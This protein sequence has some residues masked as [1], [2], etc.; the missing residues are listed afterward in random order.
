MV[1]IGRRFH[2]HL[3]RIARRFTVLTGRNGVGKS[4]ILDAI[5]FALTGTISKFAVTGAKGGGLEE[6]IWWVGEG[7][8]D[9]HFVTVRFL[10]DD[11][12]LLEVTRSRDKG[13]Q[14]RVE[15]LANS[16][17]TTATPVMDGWAETLIRT[18]L[19][20]DET[21]AALSLDLPEQARFAAVRSANWRVG[22]T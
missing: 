4:T 17:C 15:D 19:I 7:S 22:W 8:A 13:I 20:R 5:E 10:D 1:N 11:G 6:H 2:P 14:G 16:L 12:K 21:L 18:T 9:S 3:V